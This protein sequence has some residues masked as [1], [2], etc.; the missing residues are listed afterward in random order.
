MFDEEHHGEWMRYDEINHQID[1]GYQ[2]G[3]IIGLLIGCLVGFLIG[4]FYIAVSGSP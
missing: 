4:L 1:K 2:K 3:L